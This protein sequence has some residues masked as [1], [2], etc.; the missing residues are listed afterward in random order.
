MTFFHTAA[1]CTSLLSF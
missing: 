1:F